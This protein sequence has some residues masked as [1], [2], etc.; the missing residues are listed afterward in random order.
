MPSVERRCGRRGATLPVKGALGLLCLAFTVGPAVPNLLAQ[1]PRYLSREVPKTAE[2][3]P[4]P[5]A[6]APRTVDGKPDFSGVWRSVTARAEARPRQ[7]SSGPPV[8]VANEVGRNLPDGLP[9]TRYGFDLLKQ[10]LADASRDNPEARCLPMGIMQLHTNGAPRT[11]VQTPAVLAILYEAGTETRQV[12]LD[13]RTTP[14]AGAKPRWNGYSIGR[15]DGD[16]LVVATT[17]LRDGGWLDRSGSPLTDAGTLTERFRRPTISL[18]EIDVTVEDPK[19][20]A[21]PFTVRLYQ[22]LMLG[23]EVIE[24]VCL[25]NQRFKG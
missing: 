14:M 13:G 25:E 12:F 16:D 22:E 3:N 11:F 8:V 18:M 1:W 23:D 20:Y 6:P 5:N 2:G 17:N 9:V 21:K 24:S 15:W 19:V 7:P 4:D 10:R